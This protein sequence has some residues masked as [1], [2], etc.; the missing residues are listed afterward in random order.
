MLR[1]LVVSRLPKSTADAWEQRRNVDTVPTLKELLDFID[2]KAR[3]RMFVDAVEDQK[4][5]MHPEKKQD[6]QEHRERRSD[7]R[8]VRRND[9]RDRSPFKQ[10]SIGDTRGGGGERHGERRAEG[11]RRCYYC[12]NTH[13][14]HEC[15]AFLKLAVG[16]RVAEVKS[17]KACVNCFRKHD[18][19]CNRPGCSKCG[20]L[21]NTLLCL[22][23]NAKP[24]TVNVVQSE[25][26]FR[27][28]GK[29]S[30]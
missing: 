3:G 10:S 4:S 9:L 11:S 25:N 14:L 5:Q 24:A 28:K 21:H 8:F 6:P 26:R 2:G 23:G 19:V 22:K 27:R 7:G 12:G 17:W 30:D 15:E 29:G 18:G 13:R 1:S 16:K 20:G